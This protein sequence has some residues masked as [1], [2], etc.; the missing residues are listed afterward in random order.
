MWKRKKGGGGKNKILTAVPPLVM[1]STSPFPTY[2]PI[3]LIYLSIYSYLCHNNGT[4][5]TPENHNSEK[6]PVRK[7]EF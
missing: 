2:L 5:S 1:A 7:K 6:R 4:E 3:Y